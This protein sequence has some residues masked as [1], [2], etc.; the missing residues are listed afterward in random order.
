MVL[1]H[2]YTVVTTNFLA[3]GHDGYTALTEAES[4]EQLKGYRVLTCLLAFLKQ[5]QTP[6]LN[7][8]KDGRIQ[9][10]W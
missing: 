8:A 4:K 9:S 7:P 10:K 6:L 5:A 1:E 2:T 3:E